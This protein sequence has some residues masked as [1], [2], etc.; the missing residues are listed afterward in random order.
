MVVYGDL[1]VISRPGAGQRRPEAAAAEAAVRAEGY[2]TERIKAPGTLEGGDVLKVG[3]TIWVG[4]AAAPTP[5]ALTSCAPT[6]APR[7]E[8]LAVPP[9][10]VL[11]LKTAVT[12]LPDGRVIGYP[13]LVDDPAVWGDRFWPCRRRRA[14]TSC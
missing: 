3:G 10:K 9:T 12:A 13:P 6:S 7:R 8:V 11:H 4:R 2:R 1:A 14:P 5:T